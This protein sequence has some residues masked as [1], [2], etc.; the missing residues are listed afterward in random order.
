MKDTKK[1][2]SLFI[3]V[4]VACIAILPFTGL[5]INQRGRFDLWNNSKDNQ[6][7]EEKL[8]NKDNERKDKFNIIAS[9]SKN[10][11]TDK[12]SESKEVKVYTKDVKDGIGRVIIEI[13]NNDEGKTY[14]FDIKYENEKWNIMS[15]EIGVEEDIKD[16]LKDLSD[17]LS[18]YNTE[19]IS[20]SY[21][22]SHNYV[23]SKTN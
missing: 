4:L 13:V 11:N 1:Q 18:R 22:Y 19:N 5:M 3:I 23:S 20:F 16:I 6:R 12:I 17:R 2:N 14:D 9:N 8:I 21:N 10:K 15:S 7:L